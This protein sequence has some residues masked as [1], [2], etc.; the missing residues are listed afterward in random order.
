M[1]VVEQLVEEFGDLVVDESGA[2]ELPCF[3]RV[4]KI[5]LHLGFLGLSLPPSGVFAEL[6][7]LHLV[8]VQ[9]NGELT[10]DDVMLPSLERLDIR[11]SSGLASLTLRLAPLTLMTLY[12][13]RWLRRLNAELPGLEV[14]SVIRCFH[15]H[16]EGV[17]ILAEEL[18]QLRWLD[19]YWPG[20]VYFNRMPRLR[21]LV[22]PAVYPYGLQRVLFN[23]SCQMLLNL[24]PS[25]YRVVLIVD[26][27]PEQGGHH[28][29]RPLMEGI[30]QLPHIKILSL[31]LQTQGHAYGAS[32]LHILTMCT[33]IAKLSLRNQEDFQVENACPPNCLCD[34]PRNWRDKD[35]SMMS[36]REVEIL[37]FRGRQHEL[38]LVRVLVR[39]APALD[40]VRIICHRSSTA[41][42]VELLRAYVRSFASFRTSVE[43]NPPNHPPRLPPRPSKSNPK[44]PSRRRPWRRRSWR[45]VPIDEGSDGEGGSATDVAASSP[46]PMDIDG[47]DDG[48]DRG[49]EGDG[50]AASVPAADGSSAALSLTLGLHV[51]GD[52]GG[53]DRLS[54]LH[55]DI[56]AK[57]LG[58]L[59]DIR[60]VATT[61]VLSRRWLDLWTHVDIIVLQSSVPSEILNEEMDVVEQLVEEL[62]DLVVDESGA[63]ELPCFMR[64][65]KITLSL[66]FLGL[67]LPPSGVFAKL[68]ELHLVHVQFNGE[69][70]MEDAMLPSLEWLEIRHSSGLASLTLRLAPLTLMTL[71]N[72]RRLR[73]LNAVLPGL[74]V[75]SVTECFLEDLEGV[76][77]VAEELEDLRWLDMYQPGLVYFKRM[78]RLQMLLPPAVYPY[79]LQ[80]VFFNRSCQMLLNLCPSIDGLLLFVEIELEQGDKHGVRPLMEGITQLPHIK[81]LCLNLLTRGHAYGAS[82]L[83]ILTMCTGIA[84][85]GLRIEEDFQ[86]E[87]ACP[88]N[89]L[90]D[91]PRNWR[92]KDISMRSLTEIVIL[93][94]RGKQHE[95][96]LVR[97]LVLVAPALDLD[98]YGSE[99][100]D[101][102]GGSATDVA[103]SSPAPMDIDGDDDVRDRRGEG[104]GG[105]VDRLSDLSNDIL[106]KI[107]GHLRDIRNVATTAVLSRRWLDLWTHVDIIVLQYDEPP[108]SRIVQEVLA[109]HAGKGS[110][111]TDIRLLE[112]TSLNS[113]TAGATASW[114]RVAE[115]R[116][117]GELFFR[118]A[119]SVPFELLNDEMVVVEQLVEELGVVVDEMGAGFELPCFMRVTKITLSLGFLGLSLPPSGVFAKLRE[120]HLVYVRFNGELTLDDAMLPSLECLDIGKSRGLASLTLRLAPLTLMALHDMRWLRRLN[121]VLPGLK[122]LSV[123]ECFLEH[124]DGVSIVAD[125][126]EQLRWPGFYWPGL[127]YFSRMPRL[128]TLC[129]SVSDFAH[130]SREAFNQGSQMLLNRYPS[131]HH[132]ELRVV[133]KTGVTPLMVG[134][135]G[136]PYTKIL[137]LHL[138]T[139]GHSYGASVLHILTMCTRIAKLTLMIPKY[140]EVEDACA[141]I[142]ICDWLPNWRN[143]NILLEC[144][145]EVTI[146]Y[147]RGEDDELDLLKLLV[148][149][150]TGLRR[151]RIARYCSVADWEIEMLRADL[152]PPL[153]W[154]RARLAAPRVTRDDGFR[155]RYAAGK[156]VA[157]T[158]F[159][160]LGF[161]TFRGNGFGFGGY[162]RAGARAAVRV[163]DRE[164][165]IHSTRAM[166]VIVPIYGDGDGE[167]G[168]GTFVADNPPD[169]APAPM[170][171]DDDGD[172]RDRGGQGDS[173]ATQDLL[174]KLNGSGG[175]G[176]SPATQDLLSKLNGSGGEGDSAAA[177]R[178]PGGEGDSSPLSLALGLH[179]HVHGDGGG[180]D[181]VDRISNL[182]NDTLAFILGQ[183]GDTRNAAVTSVL[184]RRWINLWTQVDIL[185]LR[186]DK[187][188]DS[189]FVQ[190]ALAAHAHATEGSETTAIR[191]LEVISLNRATPEATAA[192]L[193]VAAPRLTG[194]LYF[195]NRSSAPFEALDLEV[196]SIL[197]EAVVEQEMIW[198][199][200]WFQLPCLTE[201][202]KITLS[203]GF[204]GL[205][206][207]QSGSF[208]KLRELHLEHV[209]FNG[210]Y[211]LDDAM[212]PLLEY[213]GIRRSNGLASLTLRLE[214]L[215]WMGLYDVVGIRRL[216]AVV[217]GLKALCSVGCF[218]YHDVDSVSIVAE[219][220]EEI[221]WEDFY[222]PQS[223]NFNDLPLLTMI[224][225]H[226]VFCSE[227]NEAFIEG[228]YQ[229][230]LN[231]YPRISHL[232]LRFVIEL[233]RDE[234]SVTDS[235]IDNIQL[236]YIRMLNLALKTEGH[237]Y[238]ASVLHILTKRTTIAELRLVNQEK[239]KSDDACKLECICDGP[240]DWRET[241]ISM[242]Y[243]RKVEIL[244]FRG[245]EHELDLL[246]VLVRVAPALRMIRIICHRS[247]AAWET[248]SAHIRGFAREA[249]SV[250]V[251]LS[252]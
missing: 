150:A 29:V 73:R 237:V 52:G 7:E 46:A 105:G 175:E 248:L 229:L 100:N 190:E 194:E 85:L 4:T 3:M 205:S 20:L 26:I 116:L 138:V 101:G 69:L 228:Y 165:S 37:N 23:R 241:D 222:S 139:E 91:R 192:W 89:C 246:R 8:H 81:I 243:L 196:F 50:A 217:P 231:R 162:C 171:I 226:C 48:R 54:D 74:E 143:K 227:S 132:L 206:L 98:F 53:A 21:T 218:C 137:T 109:A 117:T 157:L 90:C 223:F 13:V 42:G 225:T 198:S 71:Y 239:F 78:P 24:C 104:D 200:S 55:E 40:L 220:L 169:P 128:R 66:G 145:E 64:V 161:G 36:L 160:C 164:M 34:R 233:I 230:L 106:A 168:S 247:C 39:V 147:Y 126:M 207:P 93:N 189:R 245:E 112:V 144:L 195:R 94:F 124:L 177:A 201:V 120:L 86:V 188:P 176:D 238:G 122:E 1:V 96:D 51:H 77:I 32:V 10:M 148:R 242:R 119:S 56:L 204:L 107:L 235:M 76:S 61:A 133:I 166:V 57:I 108:D 103:A 18:E 236:P 28:G 63:F 118:N 215:G 250:E 154:Q 127:V 25:I 214:S 17:R 129:V 125:E 183:L 187:P 12:N 123:S 178:V 219:E 212:L 149:G 5:T 15:V 158:S 30:T 142:C 191:L 22:P 134:I 156:S 179:L 75:L 47:D 44:T 208:G 45:R 244:N 95:L 213:L 62:G 182:P 216:D 72:V 174:S 170:D 141:E 251:S 41:F 49:G 83:H 88:V 173:P 153:S 180:R 31:N 151:I 185:I 130:G 60:N 38:D 58:H 140:F 211:T 209:R 203:L 152:L 249:T 27:E 92:D 159:F 87:N 210:D 167:G 82:V 224:H 99:S 9:F 102:E 232:D 181:G 135:T 186:Y 240:P 111:A 121:A 234:K 193:R 6:R 59:R 199:S 11:H 16:L 70:T 65:T 197:Y 68:R 43:P 67:S 115:P 136:L 14:L 33:G 80:N 110:T 131:I 97:V 35:I 172:G 79:G 84:V 184:S 114:L 252:E 113:A 2:F 155:L 163:I 221:E 146:L 202:T 19:L